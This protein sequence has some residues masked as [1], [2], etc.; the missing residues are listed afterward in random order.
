MKIYISGGITGVEDHMA[1]FMRAEKELREQGHE[2]INP[3]KVGA[4]LPKSTKHEEYMVISFAL[5]R[6]CDAVY[7]LRGWRQSLGCNQEYGFAVGR[8]L[9]MYYEEEE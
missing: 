5:M 6:M 1:A 8:G 4:M 2:V 9:P 3:A 7:F